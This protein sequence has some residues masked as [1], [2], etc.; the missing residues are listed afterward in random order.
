MQWLSSN[1][2]L[3]SWI[4]KIMV[5]LVKISEREKMFSFSKGGDGIPDVGI[6]SVLGGFGAIRV[7]ERIPA[8]ITNTDACIFVFEYCQVGIDFLNLY[9]SIPTYIMISA[10]MI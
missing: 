2:A 4:V 1:L 7:N 9:R 10:R 8:M 6:R 3:D 5:L